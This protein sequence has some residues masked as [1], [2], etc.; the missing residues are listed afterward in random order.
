MSIVDFRE[1]QYFVNYIHS[2]T[3]ALSSSI[4]MNLIPTCHTYKMRPFSIFLLRYAAYLPTIQGK[5]TV[6]RCHSPDIASHELV[7]IDRRIPTIKSSSR[8][9]TRVFWIS[10]LTISSQ[11]LF[12]CPFLI[13]NIWS[14]HL[15][16]PSTHH[17]LPKMLKVFL[18][19]SLLLFSLLWIHD[20]EV[21]AQEPEPKP[22][23]CMC[24]EFT[25]DSF[26]NG[27]K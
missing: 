27:S 3:P 26:G 24:P 15:Y 21:L 22:T 18:K 19:I 16:P 7:W 9:K 12:Y 17:R 23:T 25:I 10:F 11:S 14:S 20:S 6:H 13:A 5:S 8:I 4:E 1:K 2:L